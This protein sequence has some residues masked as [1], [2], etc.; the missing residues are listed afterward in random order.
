[1]EDSLNQLND[2][3][4]TRLLGWCR[5]GKAQK[6]Q[7]LLDTFTGDVKPLLRRDL[8]GRTM[9]HEAVA[10]G[11]H[12]LLQWLLQQGGD[13]N[14]GVSSAWGTPLHVAVSAGMT[15]CIQVLLDHGAS[16]FLLDQSGTT[17]IHIAGV[18][19]RKNI[20]TLLNSTG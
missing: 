16:V 18:Q 1:M 2:K 14:C 3:D 5:R 4:F 8:Q 17:P 12:E 7:D 20:L 6:L 15:Q 19:S 11:H 10:G 9:L 13:P